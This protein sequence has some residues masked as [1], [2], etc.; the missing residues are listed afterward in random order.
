MGITQAPTQDETRNNTYEQRQASIKAQK[1]AEL[2]EVL[3]SYKNETAII[4]K[5][6]PPLL[7]FSDTT[8]SA[9]KQKIKYFYASFNLLLDMLDGKTTYN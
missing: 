9:Y 1:Q 6:I 4:S 3:A 5:K 2:N 7:K 8:S